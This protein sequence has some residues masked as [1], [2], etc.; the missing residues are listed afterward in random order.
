MRA[1]YKTLTVYTM[2]SHLLTPIAHITKSYICFE[3]F[4]QNRVEPE[5]TAPG[6]TMFASMLVLDRHFQMQLF[7][8]RFKD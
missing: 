1:F 5:Q 6:Y 3:A 8:W 4:R 2:N 7:C